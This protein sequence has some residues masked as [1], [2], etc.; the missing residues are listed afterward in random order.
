MRLELLLKAKDVYEFKELYKQFEKP[1]VEITSD[2]PA[3]LQELVADASPD[4]IRKMFGRDV[5]GA[6][7]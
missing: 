3:N 2:P 6:A 4:D 1:K 7:V 5:D